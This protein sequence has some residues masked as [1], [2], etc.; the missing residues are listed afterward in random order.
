MLLEQCHIDREKLRMI[1]S[2]Y[3][4]YEKFRDFAEKCHGR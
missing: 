2:Q 3:G 1:L 4:M